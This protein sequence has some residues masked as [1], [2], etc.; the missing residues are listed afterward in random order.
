MAVSNV[1]FGCVLVAAFAAVVN[2]TFATPLPC[3]EIQNMVV[4]H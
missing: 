2:S 3:F 4:N 1:S